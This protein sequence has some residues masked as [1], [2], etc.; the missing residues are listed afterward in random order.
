MPMIRAMRMLNAIEAGTLTGEALE[1][2]LASDPGRLA[3]LNVLL[4]MRGQARRMA[5]SSTAMTAV[6]ASSTAMTAVA[7]SS[8]AR[9]AVYASPTALAAID[10]SPT[11]LVAWVVVPAGLNPG[12]YADMTAVAASSTAMTAVIA[13]SVAMTAVIA[14]STA[15]LAIWESDTA[16][17]AIQASNTAVTT[18]MAASTAVNTSTNNLSYTFVPQGTKVIL[19]RRWYNG[20]PEHDHLQWTRTNG[21]L[22]GYGATAIKYGPTYNNLG[23]GPTS[24]GVNA[25]NVR[26]CNGLSRGMWNQGDTL[27]VRYLPV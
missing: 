25:N 11:G 22:P 7:A 8:T 14:S 27:Y 23:T 2:L 21:N 19:L 17:A 20:A 26:A 24:D 12:D 1:T 5:A 18:M 15:R 10:A 4:G 9:A 3:E 16:L 13:S 6:V